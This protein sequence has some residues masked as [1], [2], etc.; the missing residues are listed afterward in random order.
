MNQQ[1][2]SQVSTASSTTSARI[3]RYGPLLLWILFI[4]FASTSG[5]SASKTSQFFRPLVLWFFPNLS[6][7]RLE[8]LHFL[9]RK[10][11]H[12]TEY[13]ALAY[14]AR[15]A[16]ITS[17]HA[18]IQRKWFQLALVLVVTYAL[19]DE[20]HQRFEPTRTASLYDSG[21]DI[22]GGLTILLLCKLWSSK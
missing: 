3:W 22:V 1:A 5:F 15:R 12:F 6:E 19:L 9:T 14:L 2:A 11:G 7:D 4:S 21:I 20:L 10:L 18:F 17:S 8:T 13:A 16:F